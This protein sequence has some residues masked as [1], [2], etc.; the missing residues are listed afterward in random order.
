MELELFAGAIETRNPRP[1]QYMQ[2]SLLPS[3]TQGLDRMTAPSSIYRLERA[4]TT[5]RDCLNFNL[6]RGFRTTA[7]AEGQE[8]AQSAEESPV[9][10][11]LEERRWRH[12]VR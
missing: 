9:F 1:P 11:R 7:S 5:K 12:R 4:R 2:F 10:L 3:Q 6:S 8:E